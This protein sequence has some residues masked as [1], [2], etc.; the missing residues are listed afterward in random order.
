MIWF[1]LKN[2]WYDNVA[3]NVCVV[4]LYSSDDG[5]IVFPALSVILGLSPA[6]SVVV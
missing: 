3:D 1:L 2:D 4:V 6:L 5:I